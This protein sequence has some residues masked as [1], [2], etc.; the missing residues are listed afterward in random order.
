[1][2]KSW[3]YLICLVVIAG[4]KKNDVENPTF[5]DKVNKKFN[6]LILECDEI[7]LLK[8]CRPAEWELNFVSFNECLYDLGDSSNDN[9]YFVVYRYEIEGVD[10]L[11]RYLN[12]I[13]LHMQNDS[14]NKIKSYGLYKLFYKNGRIDYYAEYDAIIDK[15]SYKIFSMYTNSDSLLFDFSLCNKDPFMLEDTYQ[16]LLFQVRYDGKEVF[17]PYE[18]ID[19]I[20]KIYFDDLLQ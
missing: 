1:M 12:S 10:D 20:T 15:V 8:I 19:S 9:E 14:T 7:E 2:K 3:I 4:C 16:Q 18:D 17:K 5:I 6:P 13:Y 11:N